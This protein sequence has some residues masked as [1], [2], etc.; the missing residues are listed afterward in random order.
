MTPARLLDIG[1]GPSER[2]HA[3]LMTSFDAPD[4]T[5]LSDRLLPALLG[6]PPIP[7]R[8][9]KSG[10][11]RAQAELCQALAPLRERIVIVSSSR[12]N[13]APHWLT[14]YLRLRRTGADAGGVVQH[15]KLWMLHWIGKNGRERLEL[16]V[17]SANLTS[18]GFDDQIQGVWRASVRLG[19]RTAA[20]RESWGSL[21]GFLD[22]L[23]SSCD[24]AQELHPF[25]ELLERSTCPKDV[26]FVMTAPGARDG[27][28]HSLAQALGD[29]KPT[30][31]RIMTPFT[32]SWQPERLR[33]WL[34]DSGCPGARIELAAAART[35]PVPESTHWILS[36]P[37]CKAIFNTVDF[38]L[39][40]N[41]VS[42]ALRGGVDPGEDRRW[43]HAKLYEFKRGR[44]SALLVTSANFTPT[45]WKSG[46]DGNFELGVLLLGQALPLK[47]TY[48]ATAD[49]VLVRGEAQMHGAT[50]WAEAE[51][52]GSKVV[53]R[54]RADQDGS[55]Q[56]ICGGVPGKP[57][58]FCSMPGTLTNVHLPH[59][60]PTP[61]CVTIQYAASE[62]TIPVLDLRVNDVDLPVGE[63][64]DIDAQKWKDRLL[65]ERYGAAIDEE[66]QGREPGKR[67]SKGAPAAPNYKLALFEQAQEWFH[68]VDHWAT[69][70]ARDATP[71]LL[72]D[73]AALLR[74]FQRKA[75]SD[76]TKACAARA[77]V[78][79]LTVRLDKAVLA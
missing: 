36:E 43:T 1:P 30:T 47:F 71:D 60:T 63:L 24:Q 54:M 62:F 8:T 34:Q 69:A 58:R 31:V 9:E 29:L 78:D 74:L 49:A 75:D 66:G 56:V 73:G 25:A 53:V 35:E 5:L 42:R 59:T 7:D 76:D 48:A 23:G 61:Q 28:V 20:Q 79:E 55:L 46:A 15:A 72:N 38:A 45:A 44:R 12:G 17:S 68:C 19:Q 52:D 27:G 33:G 65:L 37:T 51:W 18:C 3:A 2:L 70:Y 57:V 13:W 67:S 41:N 40:D 77:V 64:D 6:L 11:A 4:P 50:W 22:R 32:G 39:L 26:R 14:S 16:V 10:F 21:P